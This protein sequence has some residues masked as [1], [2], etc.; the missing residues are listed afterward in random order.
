MSRG[1]WEKAKQIL[2]DALELPPAERKS[3]IEQACVDDPAMREEVMS[4]L[5]A[6]EEA[7]SFLADGTSDGDTAGAPSPFHSPTPAP[8]SRLGPYKLLQIIGEGGFGTVYLAEQEE[9]LRR[10]V[11]IKVIK[12]G[13]D[14]KQ[15]LARFDAE[16]NALSMM[17]HANI[18]RVLDAGTTDEGRPYF[19]MELVRGV[20]ITEYCDTHRLSIRERL[21]LFREV[22][23]GIQHAH[24]KG[25]IHRDIKPSNVL[26]T[27][28]DG[29]AVPKVID[30]GVAKAVE[31]S[32]TEMTLLTQFEQVI[33]TLEYMSPEQADMRGLD[34]DTRSD[35]YALGVLLYELLTGMTPLGS[36][37]LLRAGYAEIQR[38]IREETPP[39]P[40][41]RMSLKSD[42]SPEIAKVRHEDTRTLQRAL[43]GDLDWIV[44][45]ALEKDRARRYETASGFEMDVHR[46]ICHE[47]VQARPPSGRYLAKKFIRRY[48]QPLVATV[49]VFAALVSGLTWALV[50]RAEKDHALEQVL[51]L[52]DIK[53]LQDFE[54]DAKVLWPAI[55]ANINNLTRWLEK[56]GALYARLPEHEQ[57]LGTLGDNPEETNEAKWQH[58][59]VSMLVHGL[60][61]FGAPETGTIDDVKRRLSF[62]SEIEYRSISSPEARA[63][64]S[65]ATASISDESECPAYEGFNL[66][67]QLALLPL[68]RNPRTGLH[69]FWHLQT[70]D[71]PQLNG[72][73]DPETPGKCNRWVIQ[74]STSLVFVLIPGGTFRMGAERPALG[75]E[76]VE[77][78]QALQVSKVE[79]GS[80][81]SRAGVLV[82]DVLLAVNELTVASEFE[83]VLALPTVRI[84]EDSRLRV[85]RGEEEQTVAAR[86]EHGVGSPNVDPWANVRPSEG[87]SP[88]REVT[89]PPY[90]LSK[91]EM[92]RS[93]WSRCP[94]DIRHPSVYDSGYSYYGN[95]ITELHPVQHVSWRE[96]NETLIKLGLALPSE[97]QWERAARGGSGTPFWSGTQIADLQGVAN[98]ADRSAAQYLFEKGIS[99]ST[100]LD[101]GHVLTSPVGIYRANKFGMHDVLGGVWEH[102]QTGINLYR[103]VRGGSF[104]Q[105]GWVTRSAHVYENREDF[106]DY[107]LGV[108]PARTIDQ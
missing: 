62:A 25:V 85:R 34:I 77:G 4:L 13:M 102:C 3:F 20:P 93:Q 23:N 91:Y 44:M 81:A 7:G 65:D 48:R 68:G 84:G 2:A 9:P 1:T 88:L 36:E 33:G 49:L 54:Q 71:R 59:V 41:M 42:D 67:P 99:F 43:R 16:K 78:K 40:S 83:L 37:T 55:P 21:E 39:R 75:M 69:E 105:P 90:F 100:E 45:K 24:Q 46:F 108:R 28:H 79:A 52:S 74:E 12:L 89:L 26:V 86:V 14:T 35:I 70:G 82:G 94:V 107:N 98:V 6:H 66:K 60:R 38:I 18:A 57:L 10:Q 31:Q 11:A 61:G 32:L 97:A 73:W 72:E 27:S 29:R 56:S 104:D 63:A 96:C 51:R 17:D 101:D 47:P 22:C 80:L 106:R 53:L 103:R 95:L 5:V 64:W 30:F 50:E 58:Q 15:I 76:F 19:A 8:G 87:Y 92:T